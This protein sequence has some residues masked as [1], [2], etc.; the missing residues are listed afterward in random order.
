[1]LSMILRVKHRQSREEYF[2]K[3][4]DYYGNVEAM[5]NQLALQQM[6]QQQNAM[7]LNNIK[8]QAVK[9]MGYDDTKADRFVQYV[10]NPKNITTERLAALFEMEEAHR[11]GQSKENVER[12]R[13]SADYQRQIDMQVMQ[14]PVSLETG[15]A[16][17]QLTEED[18]FNAWL[19]GQSTKNK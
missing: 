6:N 19:L 13:K 1:M 18:S 8:T 11:N 5:R 2:D 15:P 4:V 3:V 17:P 7:H 12:Q 16:T 9:A 10:R 14:P